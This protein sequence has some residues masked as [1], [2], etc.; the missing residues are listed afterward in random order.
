MMRTASCRAGASAGRAA[1]RPFPAAART[2][3]RAPKGCGRRS[4]RSASRRRGRR[5]GPPACARRPAGRQKTSSS[6][7]VRMTVCSSSGIVHKAALPPHG[8]QPR[9]EALQ[10]GGRLRLGADGVEVGGLVHCADAGQLLRGKAE[11]GLAMAAASGISRRG[12]S[13]ICSSCRR[14]STSAVCSRS[15]PAPA[16]QAMPRFLQRSL[17]HARGHAGRAHE[18]DNIRRARGAQRAVLR[19]KRAAVQKSPRC[20]RRRTRPPRRSC[21]RYRR[22]RRSGQGSA[23]RPGGPSSGKLAPGTRGFGLRIVELARLFS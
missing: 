11:D 7:E 5:Q 3:A 21:R 6:P 9:G 17:V 4:A 13:M 12:L 2:A 1:K 16:S 20:A 22:P 19:Y 8:G 23:A 10:M 18:D 15:P 14:I